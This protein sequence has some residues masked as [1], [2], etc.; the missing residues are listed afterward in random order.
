M[1]ARIRTLMRRLRREE[2]GSLLVTALIFVTVMGLVVGAMAELASVNMRNTVNTRDQREV[3]Y[4][5][6][7]AVNAAIEAFRQS[8]D[9]NLCDQPL[10][11]NNIDD[12]DVTVTCVPTPTSSPGPSG[13]NQPPLAVIALTSN[14]AES[15]FFADSGGKP[16][17]VG[18]MYSNNRVS[19]TGSSTL[20]VEG[21]LVARSGCITDGTSSIDS[22]SGNTQCNIGTAGYPDPADPSKPVVD[23]NKYPAAVS[24]VPAY[25]PVPSCPAAG[26]VIMQPGTYT[27]GQG[28]TDLFSACAGRVFHFPASG[29]SVGVYY[30]D[31]TNAG[32]HE[33]TIN[34]SATTL[35]G[36]T[37]RT[38]VNTGNA[39]ITPVGQ[40]CNAQAA[41]V[42][43]IF[44][45]DSRINVQAGSVDLCAQYDSS[46][47]NQQIAVYGLDDR[48][49]IAGTTS[50]PTYNGASA[51]GPGF[52][53]E[54]NARLIDNSVA[55]ATVT[56][57]SPSQTITL[58]GFNMSAIPAGSK[59][60]SVDL[61]IRHHES[62]TTGQ[63]SVTG[64]LTGTG[65]TFSCISD[66]CLPKVTTATT[67]TV[68]ATSAFPTRDSLQNLSFSYT[69][70]KSGGPAGTPYTGN[71]DGVDVIV[72]YTPPTLRRQSGC[73]ATGPYTGPSGGNCAFI[74]TSGSQTNL[75]VA[76]TVYAPLAAAD[77]QLTNV[78]G[79]V[80]GR[81][82]IA[83]VIRAQLTSSSSCLPPDC[84]P[85]RLPT[86]ASTSGPTEVVFL[87]TVEGNKRLRALV[88][89]P[90]GGGPPTVK[91]W[92]SMNES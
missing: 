6:N 85:F 92:S 62:I 18:G 36:G 59:I 7:S 88:Q 17:V 66:S 14:N 50:S 35:V 48:H 42:Q 40:R 53:N 87:A 23:P 13:E 73:V 75:S 71:L 46:Q 68:S 10:G 9:E 63:L 21:P 64:T 30:F 79:Q 2:D 20:K 15:G 91:S 52:T 41:G 44:G 74:M 31:F 34:N 77:V 72:S 69:V 70:T 60:N 49:P 45:G 82:I 25:R 16:Y 27:D 57:A 80:F 4:T 1:T 55:S 54:D 86:P 78:S 24:A 43:F 12:G 32:S 61:K 89:F 81:G 29:G 65:A 38:G 90:V 22:D 37:F 26:P 67:H 47:T 3:V 76:G 33:W 28:L 5:A 56:G 51:S 8:G 11:I 84:S 83:R 58:N 19:M 39:Q